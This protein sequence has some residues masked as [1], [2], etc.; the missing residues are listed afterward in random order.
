VAFY[1]TRRDSNAVEKINIRQQLGTRIKELRAATGLSQEAFA[2]KCGFARSY[3]SRI[4]RGGANP[5]I[6]AIEVLAVALG[7][8]IKDLFTDAPVKLKKRPQE[9]RLVPYA[10]DGTCFGSHLKRAGKFTVGE[11]DDEVQ[12]E[13]F[14]EALAYLRRM[15]AA[16]W[17]RPNASGSWGIVSAVRWMEA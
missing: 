8:N 1:I 14:D 4:E 3:M 15:G 16:K 2:D 10:A 11:K 17:R 6:D 9:V 5:S 12:F 13:D 7:V